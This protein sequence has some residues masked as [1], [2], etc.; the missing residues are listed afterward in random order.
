MTIVPAIPSLRPLY[1]LNLCLALLSGIGL[2]LPIRLAIS[3]RGVMASDVPTTVIT[4]PNDAVVSQLPREGASYAKGGLL[5]RFQQPLLSED[6]QARRRELA[7]L[8]QRLTQSRSDCNLSLAAAKK[9]L[10]EAQQMDRLNYEAYS[11]QAISRLQLFQY[12]NLLN[13]IA[14]ELE[15]S[16]AKCRLEQ[17]QLRSDILASQDRLGREQVSQKFLTTL[18]ASD[19]GAVYS[20]TVKSGQRVQA[21][22]VLARFVRSNRSVAQLRI[23]SSDRPFVQVGR[24]FE[25]TSPTYSFLPNP[26]DRLCLVDTITPDLISAG[27]AITA[28]GSSSD[29]Q[30]YLLR[31]RFTEPAGHGPYPLLIGMDIVART[32]GTDVTMFQ[33]LIK[34]YRSAVQKVP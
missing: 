33:L 31:C 20:I 4:A 9:R 29:P 32:A 1:W 28:A 24:A 12:R 26:P 6:I 30:S 11:Q 27:G 25:V 22:E 34:G 18:T 7:D 15:D 23:G 3:L 8:K 16:R 5:F 13:S 14:R 17:A 10:E 21:G 19:E 2:A